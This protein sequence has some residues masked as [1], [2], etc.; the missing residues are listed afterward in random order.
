M[1]KYTK[2]IIWFNI[3]KIITLTIVISML[4]LTITCASS[5]SNQKVMVGNYY[6]KSEVCPAY[7]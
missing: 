6:N 1:N 3:E 5:C 2:N 4:I 7:H